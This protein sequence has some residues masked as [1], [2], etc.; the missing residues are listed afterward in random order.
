M[1][2]DKN[3]PTPSIN[4]SKELKTVLLLKIVLFLKNFLLLK[5]PKIPE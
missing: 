1:F 2:K 3:M 4:F 5:L